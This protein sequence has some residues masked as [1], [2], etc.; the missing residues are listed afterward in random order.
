MYSEDLLLESPMEDMTLL[1]NFLNGWKCPLRTAVA[2]LD[3]LGRTLVA[4]GSLSKTNFEVIG[5][6]SST[7]ISLSVL[8]LFSVLHFCFIKVLYSNWLQSRL[9]TKGGPRLIKKTWAPS[10]LQW[11]FPQNTYCY[12][13]AFG[14]FSSRDQCKLSTI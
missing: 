7:L 1:I 13:S 5:K 12:E 6:S 8:R 4:R 9:K 3:E 14:I 10:K 2:C 11:I